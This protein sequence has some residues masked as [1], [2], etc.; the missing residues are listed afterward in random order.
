MGLLAKMTWRRWFHAVRLPLL[1][2]GGSRS[3]RWE[4]E[5]LERRD[6]PATFT[7]N[8]L[9]DSAV[10][11]AANPNVLSLRQAIQVLENPALFTTLT[12]AQQNQIDRTNGF[13]TNDTIVFNIGQGQQ[14]ISIPAADGALPTITNSVAIN[15]GGNSNFTTQSIDIDGS[16]FINA[17]VPGVSG[18]KI[19]ADLSVISNL[20]ITL[21][22]LIFRVRKGLHYL[23][24]SSRT[25]RR[26]RCGN[27]A[28]QIRW[29]Y[30]YL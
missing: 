6:V 10:G 27:K 12:A 24:S 22:W 4:L 2:P 3:R 19:T 13:G 11:A 25:F 17:G 18:L 14:V 26:N 8:T 16:A 21:Y 9:T 28:L 29:Y 5:Q 20:T 23:F 1:S 15:G 7:V 30:I